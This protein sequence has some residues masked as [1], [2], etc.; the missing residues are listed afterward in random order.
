MYSVSGY[1]LKMIKKNKFASN[2]IT[3]NLFQLYREYLKVSMR[4]LL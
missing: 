1:F 2:V 4:V 3:G